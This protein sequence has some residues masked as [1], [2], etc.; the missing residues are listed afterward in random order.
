V[1]TLS[2]GRYHFNDPQ[3]IAAVG[4]HVWVANYAGDSVTELAAG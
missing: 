2:G 3:S 4:G 1:A